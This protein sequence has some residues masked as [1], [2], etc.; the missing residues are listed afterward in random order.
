M[1]TSPPLENT[2]ELDKVV[3]FVNSTLN[4]AEQDSVVHEMPAFLTQQ[5]CNVA[6]QHVNP[7]E[8]SCRFSQKRTESIF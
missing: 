3:R 5:V 2:T 6:A 4:N 8:L 1:V 7:P